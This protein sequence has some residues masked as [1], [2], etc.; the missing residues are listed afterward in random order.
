MINGEVSSCQVM[1]RE[2]R[3]ISDCESFWVHTVWTLGEGIRPA[4]QI[5]SSNIVIYHA[6]YQH[7]FVRGNFARLHVYHKV[8][9]DLLDGTRI[10][11]VIIWDTNLRIY[12]HNILPDQA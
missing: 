1:S 3:Y 9:L 10:S 7:T 12:R 5:G 11:R 8:I 6:C 2:N 4:A